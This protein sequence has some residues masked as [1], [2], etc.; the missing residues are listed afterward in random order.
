LQKRIKRINSLFR[1]PLIFGMFVVLGLSFGYLTFNVLSFSRTV[2]VPPLVN[3]TLLEANEALSRAGLYL[4]IEGEDYDVS[5]QT[6]RILR[7]DIPPGNSVKE[8]RTIKVVVSKGPRVYSLP[9]IVNEKLADAESILIQKGL[10]I[11][12][13]INVHSDTVEK[14]MIV[15]QKPEPDEKVSDNIIVLVSLGPHE[16]SYYCPDFTNKDLEGVKETA[17]KMNLLVETKSQGNLVKA[18]KPKPGSIVKSGE[19]I[20]L[21][22]K[23]ENSND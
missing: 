8:K 5:M 11:G 13:I 23:E 15:A 17:G 4:K 10:R 7:Q 16:L 20:Y 2:S 18:Q 3:L 9:S 12:R 22:M 14:G 1:L 6:G 21:D 19:K